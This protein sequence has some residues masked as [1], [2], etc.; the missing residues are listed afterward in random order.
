[1]S[2]LPMKKLPPDTLTVIIRDDAPVVFC[3]STPE[4]RTVRMRLTDEQRE[5]IMLRANSSQGGNPVWESIS[6]AII[7]DTEE[8]RK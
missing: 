6:M 5:K 8:A 7:E 2:N 1:M 3:N 4:Y